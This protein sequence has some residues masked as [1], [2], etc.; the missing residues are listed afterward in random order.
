MRADEAQAA[1]RDSAAVRV[2]LA[3]R[4]R[5]EEQ[6][7]LL[8]AAYWFA[9]VLLFALALPSTIG[10]YSGAVGIVVLLGANF[11]VDLSADRKG[12]TVRGSRRLRNVWLA[13]ALPLYLA[14]LALGINRFPDDLTFAMFAAVLVAIPSLVVAALVRHA[15]SPRRGPTRRGPR[16]ETPL[17]CGSVWRAGRGGPSGTSCCGPWR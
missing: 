6:Y 1:L 12:V 11:L 15:A 10:S 4:S 8:Q 13:L 3:S 7:Y 17:P 2:R 16:C 14:A 9:A 5:W